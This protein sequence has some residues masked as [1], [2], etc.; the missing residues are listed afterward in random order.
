MSGTRRPRPVCC[1][2]VEYASIAALARAHGCNAKMVRERLDRG[3]TPEQAVA[4]PPA[5]KSAAGRAGKRLSP[6]R[7]GIHGLGHDGPG[8]NT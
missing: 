6:W 3:L 2:G 7:H 8:P 4:Q 5:S 1:A